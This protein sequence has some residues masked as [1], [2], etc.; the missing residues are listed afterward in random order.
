MQIMGGDAV[1]T[2]IDGTSALP[3]LMV[4]DSYAW[5]NDGYAVFRLSLTKVAS[6]AITVAL[7]LANDKASGLGVDYGDIGASNIQ[8]SSNGVNWINATSATFTIGMTQI[9]VRTAIIADN[10]ANPNYVALHNGEP[11]YLNIEGNERFKLNATVASGASSLANGTAALSG[12]GTIIDGAG[13]KPL[14]WLDNVVLDEASGRA[15]FSVSR[16]RTMGASTTVG[17]ATS[18]QRVLDIP[19]AATVDGGDGNDTIYASNLGDNIFGGAGNDTLYGG[20]LDDWLL[21]GDG[22]DVL[23]AGTVDPNA[24]G[25]DG[26]YLVG[27]AGNDILRGREGSDWLEGGDGVDV[28][29]GGAGDDVLAGGA[30]DGD[31]LKG[32]AG[33]DY[34][35]FRLGDGKD[36]VEDGQNVAGSTDSLYT[37]IQQKNANAALKDWTGSGLY[38]ENGAPLNGSDRVVLGAGIGL[39]DVVLVRSGTS[40]N[41]GMDLIVKITQNGVLTGDEL[42]LTGWFDNYKKVEWLEFADGQA[43]RIGDFTSFTV[44]TAGADVIIG[45]NGNDFVVGGDGDDHLQLLGGDDVGIGGRGRDEI[46]GDDG[47]DILV[48]GSDADMILGGSG[49]DMLTGDAGDDDLYGGLGNDMLSG[50]RGNDM[51]AGGLGND[52][53]RISRGDGL[54]T[55]IDDYAGTWETVWTGSGGWNTAGGYTYDSATNRLL[56][57]GTEVIFDGSNWQGRF[58]YDYNTATQIGTLSRLVP[59]AGG[60]VGKDASTTDSDVLEFDMGINIQDLVLQ[61]SGNDLL[62]AVSN[63]N[64]GTQSFLAIDD[65]ITLKEWFVSTTANSPIE[66]FVFAPRAPRT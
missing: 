1:A 53:F 60:Q 37:A 19:V 61:R 25:G 39:G 3:T 52:V 22:D 48:G 17:F 62:I 51:I 7:S 8:I 65:R 32:G 36:V 6:S 28:L 4:G 27:G 34:Y 2:V 20:R 33:G 55:L 45:T 54:D 47:N 59:A 10:V 31:S 41:P 38:S 35:L 21:G 13:T 14:V 11:Q 57:N 42:T 30:T 24:L 66:R 12:T 56:R 26:N 5:E 44:G 43:I 9:F 63:E 46:G 49:N 23:D 16:S 15:T 50:G 40:A 18:D 64:A 29:T 58:N